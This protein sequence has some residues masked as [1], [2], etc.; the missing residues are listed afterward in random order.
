MHRIF[1]LLSTGVFETNTLGRDSIRLGASCVQFDGRWLILLVHPADTSDKRDVTPLLIN[2]FL[3]LVSLLLFAGLALDTGFIEWKSMQMQNAADSAA[4]EAMYERY[5]GN[6]TWPAAGLTQSAQNGFTNGVNTVSVTMSNPPTSGPYLGDSSAFQA[7]VSKTLYSLFMGFVGGGQNTVSRQS[8]AKMIPTCIWI[9]DPTGNSGS[10]PFWLL[11][12]SMQ[13]SCGVYV[14][15]ATGWDFAVDGFSTLTSSRT[16]VVG[17]ASGNLSSGTV[18]PSAKFSA[19]AKPDPLAYIPAP[20]IS[21]CTYNNL[22]TITGG[23]YTAYPG[24]YCG[25]LT[26]NNATVN[27]SP[28]LYIIADGLTTNVSTLTGSGVT[29]YFTKHNSASY[30][31]V[32][33]NST[34]LSMSAP[35]T[36]SGG[37]IPGVV[38]FC[39]RGLVAHGSNAYFSVQSSTLVTNGIWYIANT[40]IHLYNT[41]FSGPNYLG[42]V[43]DN[44]YQYLGTTHGSADYSTLTSAYPATNGSP[45]HYEDGVLVQ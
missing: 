40:G 7:T 22:G 28:G 41:N 32:N 30:T 33:L 37:G 18:N 3:I 14:N 29:L 17:A 20:V 15:T 19:A 27:F 43:I 31:A 8:V 35:T 12:T 6:S 16:R 26:I 10:A 4:M 23:S 5:R 45:F 9:M 11:S 44:I 25:G 39:D 1:D 38:V 42:L 21:S 34:N 13:P 24:T 2:Y 36:S